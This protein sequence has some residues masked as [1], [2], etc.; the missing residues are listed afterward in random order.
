MTGYYRPGDREASFAATY[1]ETL[2]ELRRV[3][4]G[5]P[6]LLAEVGATEDGGKKVGWVESF[7]PGLSANPDVTGFVWFNHAV[8][9]AGHTNDWRL[10][11]SPSVF[12]SVAEGLEASGYGRERGKSAVLLPRTISEPPPAAVPAAAPPTPAPPTPVP[13]TPESSAAEA[14]EPKPP[15]AEDAEST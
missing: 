8:T 5:K 15:V 13:S 1:D 14:S 4:P 3:A 12:E 11:S 9:D 7:F 2:A 10:N 6:I